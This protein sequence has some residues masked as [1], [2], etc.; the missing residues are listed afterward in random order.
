M[1]AS[2]GMNEAISDKRIAVIPSWPMNV[3]QKLLRDSYPE[4]ISKIPDEIEKLRDN[5]S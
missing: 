4:Y 1:C 3:L 2:G 5:N